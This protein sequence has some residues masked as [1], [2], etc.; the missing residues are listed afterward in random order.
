[1]IKQKTKEKFFN[2]IREE[3]FRVYYFWL[4]QVFLELGQAYKM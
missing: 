2:F 4:C 1:M 3:S